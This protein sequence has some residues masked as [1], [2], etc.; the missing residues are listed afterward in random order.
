[1]VNATHK[2]IASNVVNFEVP[3]SSHADPDTKASGDQTA[4]KK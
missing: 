2:P 3:Q 1:L 4:V